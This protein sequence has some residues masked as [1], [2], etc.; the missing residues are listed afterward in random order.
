MFYVQ[1]SIYNQV[2]HFIIKSPD[3][4]QPDTCQTIMY[5]SSA[6]LVERIACCHRNPRSNARFSAGAVQF[7]QLSVVPF[8]AHIFSSN[9]RQERLL[10]NP[11]SREMS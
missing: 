2:R 5:S 8:C 4:F 1:S 7:P 9:S 6:R 10:Q 11:E 3:R